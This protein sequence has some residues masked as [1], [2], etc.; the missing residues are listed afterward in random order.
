VLAAHIASRVIGRFER[1]QLRAVN[2]DDW[3]GTFWAHSL[4]TEVNS[5]E[6]QL[7]SFRSSERVRLTDQEVETGSIPASSTENTQVTA[8][9]HSASHAGQIVANPCFAASAEAWL[10]R[11]C[12]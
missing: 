6:L 12:Y 1:E 8:P 5:G 2:R 3:L 9:A 7:M 11:F 4:S 10:T